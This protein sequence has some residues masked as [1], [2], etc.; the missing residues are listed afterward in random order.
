MLVSN[1]TSVLREIS[2]A[3][4][5][6]LGCKTEGHVRASR[7]EDRSRADSPLTHLRAAQTLA[8]RLASVLPWV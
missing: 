4:F 1:R 8:L 2:T 5:R 6:P 3:A 7:T